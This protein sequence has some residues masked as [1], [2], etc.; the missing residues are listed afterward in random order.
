MICRQGVSSLKFSRQIEQLS[1]FRVAVVDKLLH[2]V[3]DVK[4]FIS[5]HRKV[6]S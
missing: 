5:P 6:S 1:T 2:I 4:S 3:F